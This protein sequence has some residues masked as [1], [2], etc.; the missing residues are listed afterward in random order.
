MKHKEKISKMKGNLHAIDLRETGPRSENGYGFLGPQGPV[1]PRS[2]NVF[3][4]GKPSQNLKPYD[5]RAVVFTNILNMNRG[6]LHT[7]SFRRIHLTA[8]RYTDV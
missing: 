2:R 6:S 3:A 5:N 7:R 1:S 8:C 4:S